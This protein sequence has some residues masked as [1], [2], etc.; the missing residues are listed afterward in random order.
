[1]ML[2]PNKKWTILIPDGEDDR[3]LIVVRSLSQSPDVKIYVMSARPTT[4]QHSRHAHLIKLESDVDDDEARIQKVIHSIQVFKVNILMPIGERGLIFALSHQAE[5][6]KYLEI[7]P[8]P[9]Q[10]ALDIVRDKWLLNEFCIKHNLPATKSIQVQKRGILDRLSDLSYPVLLKP[11]IG[12]GGIGISFYKSEEEL[13][14]TL[15]NKL[16]YF[17][18]EGYIL[19]EYLEGSEVDMSVLCKEGQILAY[20][21]QTPIHKPDHSFSFGKKIRLIHDEVLYEMGSKIL[22][23]LNWSGVAHI[24]FIRSKANGALYPLDFNPR[25]WGTLLGSTV[26]GINFPY[27]MIRT[28]SG[29]SY[30]LP[31]YEDM[32]FAILTR[33]ELISWIRRKDHFGTIPF[34]NTNLKFVLKDPLP[35]LL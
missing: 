21:I 35:A 18:K 24:D 7:T 30:P 9:D 19:Q 17:D 5:L 31:E 33:K 11:R 13:R 23:N 32:I 10:N 22:Q 2:P 28:T 4:V 1:M 29:Q 8:L 15:H 6:R 14:K 3:A 25:F 12:E 27:L 20:T 26:S 16:D 34:K